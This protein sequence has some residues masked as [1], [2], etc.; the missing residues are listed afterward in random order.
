VRPSWPGS[1]RIAQAEIVPH[2]A[3]EISAIQPAGPYFLAGYCSGARMA[4]EIAQWFQS[5]NHK[6][7]FL[8]LIESASPGYIRDRAGLRMSLR[9]HY[10]KLGAMTAAEKSKY[11]WLVIRLH[12]RRRVM[13]SRFSLHGKFHGFLHSAGRRSVTYRGVAHLFRA[14]DDNNI[15]TRESPLLG[16]DR[17]VSELRVHVVAGDHDTVLHE[18]HVRDTAA[19]IKTILETIDRTRP[20]HL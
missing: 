9:F 1:E 11:L 10:E 12:A 19:Q 8:G 5:H 13:R 4:F 14:V 17:L 7:A 20:R 6:L 15:S 3:G 2:I 18:P 16:W